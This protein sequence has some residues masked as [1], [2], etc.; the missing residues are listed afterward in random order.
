M[1]GMVKNAYAF[2]NLAMAAFVL[3]AVAVRFVFPAV[4]AEGSAF[5]IIRSSPVTMRA[6]LWSKLWT[7]LFPILAMALGLTVVSNQMLGVG[8]F[9]RV[10]GA[11]AIVFMTFG[12]VGLAAGMGARYPRFGAENP[13]QVAGS[14]GG[15]AF[16]VLAV[17]FILATVA[18]LAWPASIYLWHQS[19][20]E[21]ITAGH[22][23]GMILC[24]GAATA[25]STATFWLPMRSG[26]R[27]LEEME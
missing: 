21:A 1:A 26:I 12:L 13:T 19:R 27:A 14:Y 23:A 10:L 9:L 5:W 18:L 6:F 15:V 8:L 25:L 20:G 3:S 24:F 11:V 16:M 17:L 7:G 2:V 22:R 4:S